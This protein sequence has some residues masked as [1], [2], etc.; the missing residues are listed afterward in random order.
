M[1]LG[2][3]LCGKSQATKEKKVVAWRM[4]GWV[5]VVTMEMGGISGGWCVLVLLVLACLRPIHHPSL[6][7][8]IE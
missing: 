2:F 4:D 8:P 5:V 1:F 6:H 7:P 3:H